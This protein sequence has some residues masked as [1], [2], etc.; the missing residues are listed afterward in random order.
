MLMFQLEEEAYDATPTDGKERPR[1]TLR[2]KMLHVV[3]PFHRDPPKAARKAFDR[4]TEKPV[5]P[6]L[7]QPYAR[8]LRNYHSHPESKFLNG[9]RADPWPDDAKA[10]RSEVRASYRKRGKSIGLTTR[11]GNRSRRVIRIWLNAS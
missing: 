4:N 7:L 1:Q 5:P 10:Y 9:S 2:R 6:K 3:A 8:A 11:D